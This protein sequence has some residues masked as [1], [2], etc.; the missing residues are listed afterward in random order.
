MYTDKGT[1]Q[2]YLAVDIQTDYDNLI[3]DWIAAVTKWINRYVGFSFEV[4][5][6]EDRFYDGSATRKQE[7]DRFFGSMTV[8]ILNPDGS[9]FVTL[10]E[11]QANDYLAYP[12]NEVQ[13]NHLV[14][15]NSS[16]IG[17]FPGRRSSVKV[18]AKFG[19]SA[20]VPEDVGLVA[21]KL[22]AQ[23]FNESLKGG[24]VSGQE[25]GDLKINYFKIDEMAEAMG[26]FEKLE[27]YRDVEI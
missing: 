15:V 17:N 7:V 18:S 14:L 3:T 24:K 11:G 4:A 16:T 12:L 23:A 26:I 13:K 22:V 6:R 19:Q 2:R 8:E 1:V 10:T 25:I 21:T 20:T 9:T 5:D 27:Q